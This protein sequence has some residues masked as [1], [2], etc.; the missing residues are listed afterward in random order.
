MFSV[1]RI[2][3]LLLGVVKK[4]NWSPQWSPQSKS[5]VP[6]HNKLG[7]PNPKMESPKSNI[8]GVPNHPLES[9]KTEKWE[10]QVNPLESPKKKSGVPSGVPKKKT[11]EI[12]T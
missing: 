7:V 12:N 8:F 3:T 4:K 1:F 9:P 11:T 2:Q 6:N 5:G 10:S